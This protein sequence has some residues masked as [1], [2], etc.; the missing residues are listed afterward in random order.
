MLS[1]LY[2]STGRI[3]RLSTKLHGTAFEY[4]LVPRCSGIHTSTAIQFSLGRCPVRGHERFSR[5]SLAAILLGL[6][7]AIPA[8]AQAGQRGVRIDNFAQVDA[9]YYRGGQPE[10]QDYEDLAA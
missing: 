3:P 8:A 6:S 4:L 5:A 10:G 2:A 1:I 7:V 9:T